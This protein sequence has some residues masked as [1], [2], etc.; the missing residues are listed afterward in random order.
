MVAYWSL[1]GLHLRP[2]V[3]WLHCLEPAAA[4]IPACPGRRPPDLGLHS[5][6]NRC[7]NV[8]VTDICAAISSLGLMGCYC[9]SI[10]DMWNI[11]FKSSRLTKLPLWRWIGSNLGSTMK[12]FQ[13]LARY[14]RGGDVVLFPATVMTGWSG[15]SKKH[16]HCFHDR[17]PCQIDILIW[18][19]SCFADLCR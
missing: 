1:D 19:L 12:R 7:Q 13:P 11:L 8:F 14:T 16:R 4:S 9:C 15:A 2:R 6:L 18:H 17:Y 5:T 3:T 10:E